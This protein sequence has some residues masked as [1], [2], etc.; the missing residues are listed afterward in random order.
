M[1][2][3]GRQ[4]PGV[5]IAAAGDGFITQYD[6]AI[7]IN[8]DGVLDVTERIDYTFTDRSHG[9]YRNIPQPLPGDRDRSPRRARTPRSTRRTT[10]S[11]TSRTSGSPARRAPRPTSTSPSRVSSWSS[12]WATLTAPSSVRRATSSRYH[13]DRGDELASTTY[14]EL[15]WNAIGTDWI[16]PIRQATV[17]VEAPGGADAPGASPEPSGSAAKCDSL[18]VGATSVQ[19]ASSGVGNGVGVTVVVATA[20]GCGRRPA[21]GLRAAVVAA[22]CVLVDPRRRSPPGWR[23]GAGRGSASSALLRQ[24]TGPALR[25]SDP[26]AD[27]AGG[28]DHDRGDPRRSATPEKGRWSGHRRTTCGRGCSAR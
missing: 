28:F 1:L 3:A 2:A 26:R 25:R 24:G 7:A 15:Y 22:A 11:S 14:D 17:R 20:Q 23:P 4:R 18:E 27:A 10:G 6:V 13:V 12:G 8:D 19:A 5:G 16:V 9:I 21:A